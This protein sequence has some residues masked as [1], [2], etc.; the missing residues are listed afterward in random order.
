ML[1]LLAFT[2]GDPFDKKSFSG[3]NFQLFSTMNKQDILADVFNTDLEGIE[4]ILCALPFFSFN[5]KKW[6]QQYNLSRSAFDR[7]SRKAE[8]LIKSYHG[9]FN[10][11]FQIGATFS[12]PAYSDKPCFCFCDGN[13]YAS[14]HGGKYSH[15]S[16]LSGRR[17][18]EVFE[19]EKSV[20]D[21]CHII[22]TFGEWLVESFVKGFG[23]P[24]EKVVPVGAGINLENLPDIKE[25][26]YDM[27]T[28]LF[29]GKEF[30]RKGGETVVEAFRTVRK[31]V[32]DA[33][34][35]LVGAD[36]DIDEEGIEVVGFVNPNSPE[37]IKKLADFYM[38]ASVFV[39]P[40][41]Y[42][43]FGIVFLEA[44]H[45]MLPCIGSTRCAMPEIIDDGQ[46]GFV[47]EAGDPKALAERIITIL[48]DES[49]VRDFGMA[50][51]EKLRSKYTWH[52]VVEK[53]KARAGALVSNGR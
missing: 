40:S 38:A 15:A 20:Y 23:V 26:E 53:I 6:R 31:E 10:S 29:I 34:L 42:E 25:R 4:K 47:V 2:I 35:L 52:N 7:R 9:D 28:I 43:P 41:F 18:A 17:Y 1:K 24:E 27:R 14:Y 50:G 13:I 48:K 36:I 19:N 8:G 12:L 22:F 45:F 49:L 30:E 37:G 16:L 39:L 51:Q 32:K 21:N 44:M 11:L 3:S 33:R 46:T 5:K